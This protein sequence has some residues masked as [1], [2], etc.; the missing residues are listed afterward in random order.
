M[1]GQPAHCVGM[2]YFGLCQQTKRHSRP[3]ACEFRTFG[4]FKPWSGFHH[5]ESGRNRFCRHAAGYRQGTG[6][7]VIFNRSEADSGWH[8][9][10]FQLAAGQSGSYGAARRDQAPYR[11][12]HWTSCLC[13]CCNWATRVDMPAARC[14]TGCQFDT[15]V[16]RKICDHY[17]IEG[18]KDPG[19]LSQRAMVAVRS[20]DGRRPSPR[21]RL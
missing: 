20:E 18:G 3:W 21:Q 14:C 12:L 11:A 15:D 9:S 17:F 6:K 7:W 10:R 8:G 5:P 2:V 1:I 13:G 16:G 19:A 4:T